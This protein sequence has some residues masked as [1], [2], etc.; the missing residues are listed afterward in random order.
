V[1]FAERKGKRGKRSLDSGHTNQ[2]VRP[3]N[4]SRKERENSTTYF[5]NSI[6]KQVYERD[7]YKCVFC[8]ALRERKKKGA[9]LG[10]TSL[11]PEKRGGKR[12]IDN[13]VTCCSIHRPDKGD[14]MPVE[15]I[16]DEIRVKVYLSEQLDDEPTASPGAT[17]RVNLHLVAEIQQYLHREAAGGK[18]DRSKAERLAIKLSESEENRRKERK[19]ELPW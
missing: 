15:Y 14:K 19:V 12:E 13:Y 8:E 5:F 16:D 9:K 2:A 18:P 10:L 6:R 1:I 7:G 3:I 11:I 4:Q 17:M